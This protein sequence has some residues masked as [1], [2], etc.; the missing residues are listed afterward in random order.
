[1]PK[2]NKFTTFIQIHIANLAGVPS[3]VYGLLEL[4]I[5]V[6]ALHLGTSVL[7]AGFL[8]IDEFGGHFTPE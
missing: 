6:R 2:K 8:A 3:V 7:A 1:M 4:T 5:F